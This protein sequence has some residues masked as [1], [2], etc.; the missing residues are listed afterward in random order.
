MNLVKLKDTKLTHRNLLHIYTLTT[1]YQKAKIRKQSN[2]PLHQRN[3]HLGTN[4]FTETK[5]L[6]SKNY[7]MLRKEIEDSSNTGKDILCSWT[8]RI[9]IVK[10]TTYILQGNF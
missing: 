6:Y 1:I 5:D 9:N 2:L 3:K 4:L 7:R 10:M 8:G